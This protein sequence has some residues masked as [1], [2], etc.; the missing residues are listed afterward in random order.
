MANIS[1]AHTFD[2]IV[3]RVR[4]GM[5]SREELGK[6]LVYVNRFKEKSFTGTYKVTVYVEF[7][8]LLFLLI[9]QGIFKSQNFSIV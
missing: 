2:Y 5:T 8:G 1:A 6:A 7:R 3:L 4:F 9:S